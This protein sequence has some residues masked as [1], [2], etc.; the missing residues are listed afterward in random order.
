MTDSATVVNGSKTE[1]TTVKKRKQRRAAPS[2]Q[3]QTSTSAM[4]SAQFAAKVDTAPADWQM[5]GN[6]EMF[7]CAEDGSNPM[8]KVN[9]TRAISLTTNKYCLVGGGRCYRIIIL[10]K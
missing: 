1:V 3:A 9:K 5:L 10:N 4:P 2:L 7:S 6:Y 8:V